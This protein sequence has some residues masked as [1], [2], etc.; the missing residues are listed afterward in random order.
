LYKNPKTGEFTIYN[1]ITCRHCGANIPGPYVP[2]GT[3]DAETMKILHG[4]YLC[5]KCGHSPDEPPEGQGGPGGG[6]APVERS[7]DKPVHND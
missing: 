6:P 3:S 5:P 2:P 1:M 4:G 7:E